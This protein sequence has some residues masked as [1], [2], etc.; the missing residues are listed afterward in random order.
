MVS[1]LL[2]RRTSPRFN[3]DEDA[4]LLMVN[5]GTQI[6]CKMLDLSL[7]GCRL[8]LMERFQAGSMVRVEVRF[9]VRG[10]VFRFGGVT[11]WTDGRHVMGVRFVNIANRRKGELAEALGEIEETIA[12]KAQESPAA[13]SDQK[14]KEK[15][16]KAKVEA[17]AKRAEAVQKP[18]ELPAVA[19]PKKM[20]PPPKPSAAESKHHHLYLMP[21]EP[22][23]A[24]VKKEPAPVVVDTGGRERR[25]QPRLGIDTTAVIHLIN[26]ASRLKGR[27]LDL[28]MGGC[29]IRTFERFPVGIYTRIETEFRVEGLPFRLAGVIQGI[30][31][32][33]TVGIRFLDMSQRKREQIEQL[34]EEIEEVKRNGSRKVENDDDDF[35]DEDDFDD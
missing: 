19:K 7:G 6:R 8:K 1:R 35:D 27:I 25:Q 20:V 4:M 26:I 32:R 2:N 16:E 12:T 31:D 33:Q 22:Q 34:M 5:H 14:V 17:V 29:R 28:S 24:L 10:I 23:G 18:Q 15:A 21:Q 30:H 3:V 9:S 11:Q 13:A